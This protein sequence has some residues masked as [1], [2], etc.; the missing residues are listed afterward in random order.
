MGSCWKLYIYHVRRPVIWQIAS[1]S[2]GPADNFIYLASGVSP[3]NVQRPLHCALPT[4]NALV[5]SVLPPCRLYVSATRRSSRHINPIRSRRLAEHS[6]VLLAPRQPMLF[7]LR[8]LA[9][10]SQGDLLLHCVL[11]TTLVSPH[12]FPPTHTPPPRRQLQ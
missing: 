10:P 9:D 3:L 11:S 1:F 7:T 5:C 6:V 2:R 8:R 12:G 4:G